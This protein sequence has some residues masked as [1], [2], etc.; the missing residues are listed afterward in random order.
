MRSAKSEYQHSIESANGSVDP[1]WLERLMLD[2]GL[3]REAF[4]IKIVEHDAAEVVF[5]ERD[6]EAAATVVDTLSAS[7]DHMLQYR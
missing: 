7:N 2:L 5:W 1:L 6:P 3:A 4:T